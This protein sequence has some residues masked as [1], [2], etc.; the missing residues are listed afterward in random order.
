MTKT[1]IV[2]NRYKRTKYFLDCSNRK[3]DRKRKSDLLSEEYHRTNRTPENRTPDRNRTPD[4]HE[5]DFET[6]MK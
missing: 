4:G 3:I 2:A 5:L 1:E 6:E